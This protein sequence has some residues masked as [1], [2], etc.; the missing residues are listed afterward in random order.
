MN[1]KDLA[2]LADA[3]GPVITRHVE[4]RLRGEMARI[5]LSLK[6][7]VAQAVAAL[8]PAPAGPSG[9]R[10]EPGERGAVGDRGEAGTVGEPGEKGD[11]GHPGERGEVGQPGEIGPR[12][13][14][15]EKGDPG[16]AGARGESGETGPRGER[17]EAGPQGPP[18]PIGEPGAEGPQG[19]A[20]PVGPPGPAGE[21]G[22]DG[23][24]IDPR[25]VEEIIGRAVS[26]QFES[27]DYAAIATRAAALI[28]P[29]RDGRD[30][31][32]GPAGAQGPSGTP[33]SD[34]KDGRDGVS[35]DDLSFELD[36]RSLTLVFSTRDR[37]IRKSVTLSGLTLY[38]GLFET[39]RT[40]EAG[41]AVTYGGSIYI[42]E[43]GAP[44][45]P[46]TPDSGW[47]LAV[48]HGRDG[49]DGNQVREQ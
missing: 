31:L 6:D 22:A 15:G 42:A 4:D 19:Q 26:K 33:G 27:V 12:G 48:K 3:I 43:R 25:E 20:G 10:G 24:S 1:A 16:Q 35:P 17:G 49:R 36:G 30:G 37:E 38:R 13:E 9:P 29:P 18:G 2:V 7:H 21:R 47:R 14:R 40:Y 32:P 11:P 44:G 34:G 23:K 39:A 41:D 45:K 5:E 46:A 28:V 8:P